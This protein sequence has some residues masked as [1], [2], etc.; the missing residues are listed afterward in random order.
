MTVTGSAVANAITIPTDCRT[1]QSVRIAC[2]NL[3]GEIHPLPPERL[4]DTVATGF[5]AGYVVVNGEIKTIG[6]SGSE[7]YALTYRQGITPLSD[8][9]PQNWLILREPGLYLYSAL[10]HSAPYLK[11]DSRIM[12]WAGIAKAIRDGMHEEDDLTRYGNAP[13]M[14]NGLRNAP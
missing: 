11:D 1:I 8:A 3:F 13:A 14:Q 4:A 10:T 6:G 2:G 9:A 5:P 12:V 7:A